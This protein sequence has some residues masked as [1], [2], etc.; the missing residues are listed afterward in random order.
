MIL[1]VES[2][3]SKTKVTI[4]TLYTLP[5][6]LTE[7]DL[8]GGVTVHTL[9][10]LTSA[11]TQR[12]LGGGEESLCIHYLA[13]TLT[14]RDLGGGVSRKSHYAYTIYLHVSTDPA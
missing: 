9:Y 5:S 10:T 7:R 13:V 1:A 8:G 2:A 6:A 11:L 4:H 14:Q 12:D 3:G